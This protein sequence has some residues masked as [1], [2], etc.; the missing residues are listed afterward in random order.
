MDFW[1][2]SQT[3]GIRGILSELSRPL[4]MI[5][6][7]LNLPPTFFL[8]LKVPHTFKNVL[9]RLTTLSKFVILIEMSRKLLKLSG[10]NLITDWNLTFLQ[11]M[12]CICYDF[13]AVKQAHIV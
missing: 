5:R 1:K 8:S 7:N 13:V 9:F 2:I 10:L 11:H 3:L 4:E 12:L 6:S